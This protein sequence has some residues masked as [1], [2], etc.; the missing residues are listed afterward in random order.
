MPIPGQNSSPE[1]PPIVLLVDEHHASLDRY[2]RCLEDAGL[3]VAVTRIAGEALAAAEELK[4]DIIVADADDDGDPGS[5]ERIVEA[6]KHHTA[7]GRVPI[8]LLTSNPDAPIEA[9]SVLTK[10][11]APSTLLHR[12]TELLARSRD[13]RSRATAVIKR[14]E[15]LLDRSSALLARSGS[16]HRPETSTVRRACPECGTPLEWV[17]HATI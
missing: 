9:D 10:P 5:S 14:G 11:V 7:L 1:L 2:A 15:A 13:V 17:E 6:I 12:T 8:I 3:W 4:P 16:L